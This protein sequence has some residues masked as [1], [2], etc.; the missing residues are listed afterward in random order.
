MCDNG[1]QPSVVVFDMHRTHN[2]S[3]HVKNS[4]FPI[5]GKNGYFFVHESTTCEASTIK[6]SC[7]KEYNRKDVDGMA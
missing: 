7:I 5:H 4:F 2:Y 6:V 1:K 3:T